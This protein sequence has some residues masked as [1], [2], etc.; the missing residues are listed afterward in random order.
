MLDSNTNYLHNPTRK[1]VRTIITSPLPVELHG[2]AADLFLLWRRKE[3]NHVGWHRNTNRNQ[4]KLLK[5]L[6]VD[7]DPAGEVQG[8]WLFPGEHLGE[9]L[10]SATCVSLK[11]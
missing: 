3:V 5:H 7:V 2:A 10:D 6:C 9:Q 4:V 11:P 1:D 8:S